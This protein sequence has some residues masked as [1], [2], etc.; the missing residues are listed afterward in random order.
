[1][2]ARSERCDEESAAGA[3]ALYKSYLSMFVL[4]FTLVLL[5]SI[6]K[7]EYQSHVG[8]FND[9]LSEVRFLRPF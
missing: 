2:S 8:R 3:A 5:I 4:L 7:R 6:F 9:E 1:M